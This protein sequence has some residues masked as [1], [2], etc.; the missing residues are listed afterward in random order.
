MSISIS[1][2]T[3]RNFHIP[4]EREGALMICFYSDFGNTTSSLQKS[5]FSHNVKTKIYTTV[6]PVTTQRQRCV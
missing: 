1:I 4:G 5:E 3:F 6:R 2:L